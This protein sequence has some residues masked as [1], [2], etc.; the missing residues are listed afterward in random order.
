[1]RGI[2]GLVGALVQDIIVWGVETGAETGATAYR[3]VTMR[4]QRAGSRVEGD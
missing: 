1:M 3:L 2:I 4:S